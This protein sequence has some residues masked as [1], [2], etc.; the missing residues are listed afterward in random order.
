MIFAILNK[1]LN[2]PLGEYHCVSN[3]IGEANIICLAQAN[4]IANKK[5]EKFLLI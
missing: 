5:A 3:I 4:I 1:I 2:S